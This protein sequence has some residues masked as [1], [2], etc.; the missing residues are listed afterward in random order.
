MEVNLQEF[1]L[2]Q[3][4][5]FLNH[6]C[7]TGRLRIEGEYR[8][9]N[10]YLTEGKVVH[11]ECEELSGVEALYD[12]SM[13]EGGRAFFEKGITTSQRTLEEDAGLLV[14]EFEKRRVEF[15]ELKEKIPP[16]DSIL[17]KLASAGIEGGVSLRRTDWQILA[18]I[19]GKNTLKDIITASKIGAFDAYKSIIWLKEQG[20][21][22]DPEE[23]EHLVEK[24]IC[25]IDI[26]LDEFARKGV[27]MERWRIALD[28]WASSSE[29]NRLLLESMSI[30]EQSMKLKELRLAKLEKS[31]IRNLFD[32]LFKYLETEGVNVYGKILAKRKLDIVLKRIS[33]S[34]G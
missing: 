22:F 23:F 3:L 27:G 19:D 21:I 4:V 11:C 15:K 32:A 25:R 14:S 10:I 8:K 24:E 29:E 7:K 17:S 20:L 13:E 26:F 30:D 18:L 31:Y 9:G 34:T 33:E 2:G 28:N 5:L 6:S 12:L 1:E 16:L